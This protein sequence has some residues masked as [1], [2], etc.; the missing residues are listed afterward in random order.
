MQCYHLQWYHLL[1]CL[2]EGMNNRFSFLCLILYNL[3]HLS[4]I[5]VIGLL[6]DFSIQ[7]GYA[8]AELQMKLLLIQVSCGE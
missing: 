5:T 7:L 6:F 8:L 3:K 4:A 2:I 1:F